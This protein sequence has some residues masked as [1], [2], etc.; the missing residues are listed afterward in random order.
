LE[1]LLKLGEVF[2]VLGYPNNKKQTPVKIVGRRF[3][4]LAEATLIFSFLKCQN[5][6]SIDTRS[7]DQG[8]AFM[9]GMWRNIFHVIN[10]VNSRINYNLKL[11]PDQ[12]SQPLKIVLMNLAWKAESD[13]SGGHQPLLLNF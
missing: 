8:T 10:F 12:T 2:V 13:R 6:P 7:K 4:I 1:L 5:P 3:Q 9:I 11:R